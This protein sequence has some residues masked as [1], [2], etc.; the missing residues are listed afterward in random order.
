LTALLAHSSS[1]CSALRA[2]RSRR[3]SSAPYGNRYIDL[4][5]KDAER[6]VESFEVKLGGSRYS[7]LQMMTDEWL[8][9]EFRIPTRLFRIPR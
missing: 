1:K 7:V 5:V 9:Q 6:V 3:A 2:F 8:F 4:V